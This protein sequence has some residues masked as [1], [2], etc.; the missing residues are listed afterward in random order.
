MTHS[1]KPKIVIWVESLLGKGHL[2]QM[3]EYSR[4]L[5]EKGYD[6]HLV[7]SSFWRA[8]E[9]KY[10]GAMLHDLGDNKPGDGRH[11]ILFDPDK[12][13]Y[14]T[15]E[16]VPIEQARSFFQLRQKKLEDIIDA[17]KP[18]AIVTDHYP[19]AR[20]NLPDI[21]NVIHK[22]GSQ[23]ESSGVGPVIIGEARDVIGAF[24]PPA[25]GSASAAENIIA[26]YYDQIFVMSDP[27]YCEFQSGLDP[28]CYE[29]KME[30]VGYQGSCD[31][32]PRD[33]T[34]RDADRKIVMAGG[35][36]NTHEWL[37]LVKNVIQEFHALPPDNPLKRH[38][39]VVYMSPDYDTD[40]F[41]EVQKLAKQTGER[42]TVR[43]NAPLK[44]F[45]EAV[46]NAA[47][48]ISH[49]GV[50]QS[51]EVLASGVPSLMAT[52]ELHASN[53]EQGIRAKEYA[54]KGAPMLQLGM[55]TWENRSVIAEHLQ[56]LSGMQFKGQNTDIRLG[57]GPALAD[58]THKLL[59][60]RGVIRHEG[61]MPRLR[62]DGMSLAGSTS[63]QFTHP[64]S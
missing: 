29:N 33:H 49:A 15:P 42:I 37:A 63:G 50:N 7:S 60:E 43:R 52:R 13:I 18:D 4:A 44:E 6:V 64:C 61:R 21:D 2:P 35:N 55:D 46:G 11:R 3:D 19:F 8:P 23:R 10:G 31:F 26:K 53:N 32:F 27:K 62:L 59:Q 9:L 38:E 25:G 14:T 57:G 30:Y 56:Q 22:I 17:I 20:G 24:S 45:R 54:S 36:S 1:D 34:I 58:A 40:K 5:M 16:G 47:Y 28:K 12:R 39:L 48:L 41:E 51:I